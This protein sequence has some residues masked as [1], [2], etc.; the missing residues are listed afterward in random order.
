V[1]NQIT[2]QVSKR[3]SSLTDAYT[4]TS[5]FCIRVASWLRIWSRDETAYLELDQF[6]ATTKVEAATPAS[7]WKKKKRHNIF[8]KVE[9]NDHI[10]RYANSYQLQ[11]QPSQVLSAF[12]TSLSLEEYTTEKESKAIYLSPLQIWVTQKKKRLNFLNQE[13]ESMEELRR[14]LPS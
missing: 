7:R 1:T 3:V 5:S 13:E 12:S 9:T 8:Q 6:Q 11:E 10:Q 14:T 4:F 2:Q